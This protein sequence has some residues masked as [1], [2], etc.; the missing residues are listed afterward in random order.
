MKALHHRSYTES[1]VGLYQRIR[2]RK[3]HAVAV[4]AVA[5]H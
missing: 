1:V 4:G 3:G 2:Q 5:R